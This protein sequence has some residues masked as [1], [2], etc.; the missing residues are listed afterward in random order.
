M[1]RRLF[2]IASVSTLSGCAMG[3]WNLPSYSD[4]DADKSG[5]L[6]ASVGHATDFWARGAVYSVGF[7]PADSPQTVAFFNF[8]RSL[9]TAPDVQ[10]DPIYAGVFLHR[11]PPGEYEVYAAGIR[12]PGLVQFYYKQPFSYRFRIEANKT[13]YLG[14]FLAYPIEG[15]NF[16]GMSATAG[17][18]FKLTDKRGRDLEIVRKR[19]PGWHIGDVIPA[20]MTKA[21]SANS[22]FVGID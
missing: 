16:L 10:D 21:Q 7:R 2:L 5:V 17:F 15:K 6:V 13:T 22:P 12:L 18:Y 11:L 1:N 14:E 9:F 20:I 19:E 8:T 4:L 3:V